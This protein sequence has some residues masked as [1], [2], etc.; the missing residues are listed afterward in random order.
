MKLNRKRGKNVRT[1]SPFLFFTKRNW[2]GTERNGSVPSCW[3]LIKSSF[4]LRL[5]CRMQPRGGVEIRT[6]TKKGSVLV[7]LFW[8]LL[9]ICWASVSRVARRARPVPFYLWSISFQFSQAFHLSSNFICRHLRRT[10][11]KSWSW[12]T[13]TMGSTII[14]APPTSRSNS[15]A[16]TCS[17][18]SSPPFRTSWRS[19]ISKAT[20]PKLTRLDHNF[21]IKEQTIL[22]L[23]LGVLG[24]VQI[25]LSRAGQPY[26][27]RRLCVHAVPDLLHAWRNGRERQ[28]NARGKTKLTRR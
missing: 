12:T 27:S 28:R 19:A 7:C 5:R 23:I 6:E 24:A 3:D 11:E 8:L 13:L 16:T 17:R 2:S 9:L 21:L 4:L 15:T 1:P 20:K 25:K 14:G 22:T 26:I 18:R 10:S